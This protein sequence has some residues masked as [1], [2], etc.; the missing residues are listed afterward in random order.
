[1]KALLRFVGEENGQ[2]IMEYA[3]IVAFAVTAMAVLGILYTTI[4]DKLTQAN[5]ELQGVGP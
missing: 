3:V 2:D 1:M 5:T 4:R